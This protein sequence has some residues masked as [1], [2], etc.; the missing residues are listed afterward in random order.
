LSSLPSREPRLTDN[1]RRRLTEARELAAVPARG[2]REFTGEDDGHLARAVALSRASG[3]S[4]TW[5][6]SPSAWP[7]APPWRRP[8]DGLDPAEDR[9]LLLAGIPA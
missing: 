3:C 4:P 5:P 8:S 2:F 1:D 9:H 7:P 6:T